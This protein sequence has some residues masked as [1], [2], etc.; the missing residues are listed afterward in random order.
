MNNRK[1]YLLLLFTALFLAGSY[2][3]RSTANGLGLPSVIESVLGPTEPPIPDMMSPAQQIDFWSNRLKPN[4]SDYISMTHLGRAYLM[5]ARETGD[6]T[7]Y[8]RAEEAFRKALELNPHYDPARAL[9]GSVLIGRHAFAEALSNAQATLA[10][11][12]ND[13]QALAVSGDANLELGRYTA[14]EESYRQLLDSYPGGPIYSRMA[15]LAWLQGRPDEAIDWMRKA[16]DVTVALDIGGEELAWYRFQLGELYFNTG[17]LRSAQKWYSEAEQAFPTYYLA[18]SGLG[19]IA[20]ARGDMDKAIAYYE[21]LV[22]RLPQPGFVATLGDFYTLKGNTAAAQTQYDTVAFIHR[23]D[24]SQQILYNRP[25]ALFFA[26]HNTRLDEALNYAEAELAARQDIYAY[27]TMAWVL[28]RLGRLDEARAAVDRAL[29]LGTTDAMLF[30]HAGMIDAA[31]GHNERAR[32][33][34]S[35]ALDINPN[36]DLIQAREARATLANL[37]G[38]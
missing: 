19:R 31:L 23:L 12:P 13:Y 8:A 5:Q 15:R 35:R 11:N 28:Y 36:F 21:L 37:E 38:N 18:Q 1:L 29:A 22:D 34:L 9:I 20:A 17:D 30:Y 4:T 6:A 14:A 25:M 2:V 10:V 3:V 33:N 32:E 16:A 24:E 27:D 26:N 7:S